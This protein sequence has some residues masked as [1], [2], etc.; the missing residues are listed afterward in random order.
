MIDPRSPNFESTPFSAHRPRWSYASG[1]GAEDLGRAPAATI[2]TPFFNVGRVFH[3]TARCVLG[4]SLQ[5]FEWIIV[6][7]ASTKPEALE[8]LDEYR[9]LSRRDPRVRVVDHPV[10]RGPS[11][12]RN[13]GYALARS[14]YV[15]QLDAD[16]LMEPTTVEKC[17]LHLECNPEFA[18]VN[19][20][21]VGFGAQQYL[22]DRGF[23]WGA[24]FLKNNHVTICAMVRRKIAEQVG[25]FD[26]AIRDGLEDWEFWL[27]MAE[28][29]HWG[30][31]INEHF[32]W[33]RRRP[34]QHDDWAN[35]RTWE[36]HERFR[37]TLPARFPRLYTQHQFPRPSRAWHLPYADIPAP[38]NIRNDLAK[39]RRRM[40]MLV[41]WLRMGGADKFNLDLIK[42]LAGRG[43]EVSMATTL[44]GHPWLPDFAKVTP[45][46]F[47]LGH[48]AT[49]PHFPRLLAYLINSR[50]PDVV[51]ISNSELSYTLLPYL[52]A[53]CPGP[54][55]VDYVHMEEWYWKNG[56]YPRLAAGWQPLLDLNI[57]SSEHVRRWQTERGA[58]PERAT[59][60]TTN[61]D[62]STWRA[63]ERARE[64]VR[65]RLNIDARTPV[66]LYA[67]RLMSQKQP[68]VF[69]DT[70]RRV[71]QRGK[72]FVALVA[73][74][75]EDRGRME[76]FWSEHGLW[77]H[78]RM[79]GAVPTE[80]MPELYAA[81]DVYFLPSKWEGIAVSI[82]EAMCAE[83]TVVGADVGGQPELVTRDT[84]VLI[85]HK[86]AP[87]RQS[88]VYAAILSDLIAKPDKR[89]RMGKAA[90]RRIIS[91]YQLSAMGDRM[92]ELFDRAIELHK[93]EPRERPSPALATEM[94][95]LA[96]EAV[97]LDALAD[98]LWKYR[99]MA[100]TSEQTEAASKQSAQAVLH[101]IQSASSWRAVQRV[102]Q[103]AAYRVIARLRWGPDW[104]RGLHVED[105]R[106]ALAR[107]QASRA[108]R[109]IRSVKQ[110]PLVKVYSRMKHGG[111]V[112][113]GAI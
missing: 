80:G 40:F 60:C 30:E 14:P 24:E 27:R 34:R 90:R 31:T 23:D 53:H 52:R 19:G 55:F 96:V 4:Q 85:S 110:F 11:A 21:N 112:P 89:R 79:L 66:L 39:E 99:E 1:L 57:A 77:G 71:A 25:L 7:D 109:F 42:Q 113:G 15:Y 16:D 82:Y 106:E 64:R 65:R 43:W 51:C 105:P 62:P 70:V 56:G 101:T 26:E 67:G 17:L 78:V 61:V 3:D 93:A 92:V 103:A 12:T 97:R 72:P 54:A 28:H 35:M 76:A 102:K 69:A 108:Y 44:N 6:N 13:T 8:V 86:L 111:G 9:A 58:K 38:L 50:Q 68:M 81:S 29:G 94:A 32:D 100:A 63:D 98:D 45:D 36:A 87:E 83:L 46:I 20:R 18:F 37:Q 59:V 75:G 74:D 22:W 41:P 73:G 2:L 107:V 10:N 48:L 49:L 5:N 95:R 84:G 91:G 104:E 88:I 33:Y 47:M